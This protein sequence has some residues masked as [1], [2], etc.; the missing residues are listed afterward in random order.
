MRKFLL[1][2]MTLCLAVV[3]ALAETAEPT[4]LDFGDFTMTIPADMQ[5]EM[6]D[7]ITDN[8][9]FSDARSSR[10]KAPSPPTWRW[11]GARLPP[12]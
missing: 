9:T 1:V 4:A 8:A 11:C 5:Y 10:P 7:E 2:L 3:P 6:A 12:T